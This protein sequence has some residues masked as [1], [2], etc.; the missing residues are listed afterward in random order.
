MIKLVLSRIKPAS[1]FAHVLYLSL[2][3]LMP[4]LIFV[5]VRLNVVQLALSII[6]L[7]KWRMFAVRPRFWM[8]HVRTNAVDLMV[9]VSIVMFMTHASSVL[10]QFLWAVGYAV[11]LLVIKPATSM[12]MVSIQAGI[13]QLMAFGALFVV[14]SAGPLAGLTLVAGLICYLSARHFFDS[15][16]EPYAKLLSYLWGYFGAALIW[17]LGH[18]LLYYRIVPQPVLLLTTI[19]YGLAVLYYLDHQDRLNLIL[20][21]QFIFIML[22]IVIAVL[23]LSDWGSKVV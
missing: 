2:L 15:F 23:A 20:K 19:G 9:G 16:D 13:G 6:V 4:L 5:L 22:A 8:A 7:S 3:V 18:W 12:A 17:L 14:W 1:G 10:V 11:W 21:R